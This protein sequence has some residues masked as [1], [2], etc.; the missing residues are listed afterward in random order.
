MACAVNE[1]QFQEGLPVE[2]VPHRRGRPWKGCTKQGDGALPVR[3]EVHV[4]F[5]D[6]SFNHVC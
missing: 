5:A 3:S 1:S 4:G 2:G 6:G